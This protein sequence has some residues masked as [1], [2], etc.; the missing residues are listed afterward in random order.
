M[1]VNRMS[2]SINS[3]TT[4]SSAGGGSVST[5]RK[6]EDNKDIKNESN[7]KT[8]LA[9]SPTAVTTSSNLSNGDGINEY[10]FLDMDGWKRQRC[11]QSADNHTNNNK[12][13][14]GTNNHDFPW[15]GI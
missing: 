5:K 12:K 1:G 3:I 2:T 6:C 10:A 4:V 9:P 11:F 14:V 15:W 13:K 8:A 7:T